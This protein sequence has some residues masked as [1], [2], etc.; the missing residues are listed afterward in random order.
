MTAAA[1]RRYSSVLPLPVT[2][3]S[4][5]ALERR[6]AAA[7]EP[8]QRVRCSVVSGVAAGSPAA[9]NSPAVAAG[10]RIA[11]VTTSRFERRRA[12]RQR[13]TVAGTTPRARQVRQRASVRPLARSASA[14]AV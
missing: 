7:T 13:R 1:S 11:L 8:S 14:R 3:C 10:E 5:I 2:P 6:A 9:S 4:S 12:A